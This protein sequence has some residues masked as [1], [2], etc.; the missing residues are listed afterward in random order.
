MGKWN[1]NCVSV[2]VGHI[3]RNFVNR[4]EFLKSATATSAGVAALGSVSLGSAQETKQA[5]PNI[6]FIMCDELRF[7]IVLPSGVSTAD[8]WLAR[9]MPNVYRLWQRGVKFTSHYT[10][11][12]ACSP[13]RGS[14]LT[15]LYSH[16]TW[17]CETLSHK[18]GLPRT[19]GPSGGIGRY[20]R[21]A[22]VRKGRLGN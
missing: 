1:G 2:A 7:P 8:H 20:I 13:S 12:N 14:L 11:A 9:F 6:L 21:C 18:A 16:Q 4:R 15:G 3:R 19:R 22:F 17:F 5:P 10:A